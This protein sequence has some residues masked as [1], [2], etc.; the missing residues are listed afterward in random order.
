[1]TT[2]MDIQTM[3]QTLQKFWGDKG[4]M[5]MQAYDVEKGAGTMSPYTFCGQSDRSLGMLLTLSRHAA[6]LTVVMAR[7]RTDFS[8]TISSR[9]S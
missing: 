2:K 7:I 3:I 9:L 6:Q 5:L 8:S 4:C 1:M